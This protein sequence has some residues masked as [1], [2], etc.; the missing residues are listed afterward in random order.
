MLF[1]DHVNDA[2][3]RMTGL[4]ALPRQPGDRSQYVRFARAAARLAE[5]QRAGDL[6]VAEE[7]FHPI[8]PGVL[9]L[10]ELLDCV[11]PPDLPPTAFAEPLRLLE[12]LNAQVTPQTCEVEGDGDWIADP[13]LLSARSI[14]PIGDTATYM[15]VK[16]N[17]DGREGHARS[18]LLAYLVPSG[19]GAR[20]ARDEEPRLVGW[21]LKEFTA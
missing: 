11:A 17:A 21:S 5:W 16:T 2:V 1:A 4:L 12:A 7:G 15:A 10:V 14:H 20:T 3:E 19:Q 13:S 6:L 9:A 18:Q 8:G